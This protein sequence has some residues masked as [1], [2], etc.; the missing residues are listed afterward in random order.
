MRD[1]LFHYTGQQLP[2]PLLGKV[3]FIWLILLKCYSPVEINFDKRR[4]TQVIGL[5]LNH[6]NYSL[7]WNGVYTVCEKLYSVHVE[8]PPR[9]ALIHLQC[10]RRCTD[11][12]HA[13]IDFS[14]VSG[15]VPCHVLWRSRVLNFWPLQWV[16]YISRSCLKLFKFLCWP[17]QCERSISII[18]CISLCSP[19]LSF[20]NPLSLLPLFS[21]G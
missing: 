13:P 1:I 7:K 19:S 8:L 21:G 11:V 15:M 17:T 6:A 3:L 18:T 9:I 4:F 12:Q 14:R 16:L 5:C 2:S 20:F 10:T